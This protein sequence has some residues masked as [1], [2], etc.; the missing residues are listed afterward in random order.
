MKGG[1]DMKGDVRA[2][3]LIGLICDNLQKQAPES[4]QGREEKG[5]GVGR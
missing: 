1:G 2:G 5:K 4:S 3:H